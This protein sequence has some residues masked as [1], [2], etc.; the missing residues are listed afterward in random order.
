MH[1][2]QLG[3][4]R[5]CC[6]RTKLGKL[7]SRCLK[8]QEGGVSLLSARIFRVSAPFNYK[9][10]T[11]G[12]AP[13]DPSNV[14]TAQPT[15][16]FTATPEAGS[17]WSPQSHGGASHSRIPRLSASP[18]PTPGREICHL[19]LICWSRV[20]KAMTVLFL[21][22]PADRWLHFCP[23]LL[24]PVGGLCMCGIQEAAPGR[25]GGESGSH[26]TCRPVTSI[27]S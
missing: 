11:V 2:V 15:P 26:P 24:R 27:T 6:F 17:P 19:L 7:S 4:K 5:H 18:T 25:P 20:L 22:C 23:A 12:Q 1:Q 8:G 21:G 3:R 16:G 9:S 13:G 14:S 10:A